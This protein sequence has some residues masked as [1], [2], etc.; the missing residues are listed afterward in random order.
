MLLDNLDKDQDLQMDVTIRW[1]KQYSHKLI[2]QI[3]NQ[4]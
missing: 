4:S 3:R 1:L 2:G